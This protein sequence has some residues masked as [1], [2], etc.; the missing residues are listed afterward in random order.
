MGLF[1]PE[2][3][4]IITHEYADNHQ[5]KHP[6]YVRKLSSMVDRLDLMGYTLNRAEKNIKESIHPDITTAI[7]PEIKLK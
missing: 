1:L 4:K 2:D 6:A 5:E 7:G 3:R